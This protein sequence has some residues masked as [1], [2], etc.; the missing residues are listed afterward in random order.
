MPFPN[1]VGP[2][3][4]PGK[5]RYAAVAAQKAAPLGVCMNQALLSVDSYS[6][7]TVTEPCVALEMRPTIFDGSFP[8]GPENSVVTCA[9]RRFI[10]LACRFGSRTGPVPSLR[11]HTDPARS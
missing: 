8:S 5:V 6:L 11:S 2:G 1:R 4:Y 3:M 7:D 9:V 10:K